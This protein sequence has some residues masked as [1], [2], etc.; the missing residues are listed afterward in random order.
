[1]RQTVTP[2]SCRLLA[3]LLAA[4]SARAQVS[5]QGLFNGPNNLRV[6]GMSAD[7]QRFVGTDG[8][9]LYQLEVQNNIWNG[10]GA[11][12]GS[13]SS[14]KIANGPLRIATNY[15]DTTSG[16]LNVP[17]LW[18]GAW[19]S[20]P[21]LGS[22]SSGSTG[23]A[24]DISA[25]GQ[26]IVGLMWVTPGEANAFRWTAAG[27]TVNLAPGTGFSSRANAVSNNGATIVGWH[28]TNGRRATR[29]QGGVQTF[30]GSLDPSN[31]QFGT[32]EALGVSADGAVIVGGSSGRAFRWTQAGGLQ[33]LGRLPSA[34]NAQALGVSGDGETVVG[35]S[36]TNFLDSRAVVWR[37]EYGSQV[38]D[39]ADLLFSL[40]ETSAALWTLRIAVDVSDD[41]SVIAGW[42]INPAGVV[43]SFRVTLPRAPLT[44]CTA[45]TTTN[46][47]TPSISAPSQPSS[48]F[49]RPC[50]VTVSQVE[51]Q[52]A[53]LVF[54]GIAGQNNVSWGL[55]STSFF[56]VKTPVQRSNA[57]LSGGTVGQCDG[58]L[59]LD[60]NAFRLANPT[61]LGSPWS[62]GQKV[63]MQGWFRDPPAPRTTNLSNALEM[64]HTP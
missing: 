45:G 37:P 29:W 8:F 53:G 10:I 43:E 44:Y 20:L 2:S 56:C 40:G 26:T 4:A 30:L 3:V 13:Y 14:A 7:G 28:A 60:W 5:L 16:A 58:A 51:G 55:G 35:W 18:D 52:R 15:P 24:Y 41:G 63:W 48:S 11:G 64:T 32:S 34:P 31:P 49:A 42:G 17:S 1:M 36:G 6:S 62:P 12:Q 57:Q 22:S 59:A 39:L 50:V 9:D 46:G 23:T 61:G 21:S 47:C 25:D 27:G 38:V 19:T 54:F 33:N